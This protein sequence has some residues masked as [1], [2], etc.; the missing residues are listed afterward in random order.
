[1]N[2]KSFEKEN[3]VYFKYLPI[4]S[5]NNK[6]NINKKDYAIKMIQNNFLEMINF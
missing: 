4:K 3:K 5:R 6:S 2:Y 1:M